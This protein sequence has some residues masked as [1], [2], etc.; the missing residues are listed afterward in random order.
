MLQAMGCEQVL[1][2]DLIWTLV[3]Y[4]KMESKTKG[5]QLVALLL[6]LAALLL[7]QPRGFDMIC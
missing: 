4:Q 2:E 5:N 6:F 3:D 7:L 1:L